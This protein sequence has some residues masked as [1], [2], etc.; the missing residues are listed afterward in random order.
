[1]KQAS[2]SY[3]PDERAGKL[4]RGFTYLGLMFIIALLGL[5]SALAGSSW[6]FIAQ[7]D[8]ERELLYV[9]REYRLAIERY[10]QA[11]ANLPQPYPTS[12]AQLLGGKER[13]LTRRY[14]RRLYLD[15]M[16]GS[17]DWG[18]VQTAQGGIVGVYSLSD[19]S[20][21][22]TVGIYSDERIAYARAK[23]YRDWVFAVA[24]PPAPA[25]ASVPAPEEMPAPVPTDT[26]PPPT[27]W[28]YERDG[29]PPARWDSTQ[30]SAASQR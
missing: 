22:R 1:M 23:T 18:L 21:S 24:L 16:T 17:A 2:F 7:R 9:G 29:A 14:L 25:S 26:I 10:R 20:P 12:L 3:R 28:N 11:H 8:Q 27:D 19:R 15:P 4:A 30:R 13:L 5:M 6:S